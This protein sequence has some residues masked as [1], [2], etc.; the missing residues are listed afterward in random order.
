MGTCGL[1]ASWVPRGP[2][3][4]PLGWRTAAL[5]PARGPPEGEQTAGD[6]LS[7]R[8]PSPLPCH[9]S[10]PCSSPGL[11]CGEWTRTPAL[12]SPGGLAPGG[13][14]GGQG[15]TEVRPGPSQAPPCSCGH[16]GCPVLGPRCCPSALSSPRL[17]GPRVPGTLQPCLA[18][19]LGAGF[20]GCLCVL[21]LSPMV[22][23][24]SLCHLCVWRG[25]GV[26]AGPGAHAPA[27]QRELLPG[28]TAGGR[29][30]LRVRRGQGRPSRQQR[31]QC[32]SVSHVSCGRQHV[33]VVMCC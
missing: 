10:C 27:V 22:R 7:G 32:P 20:T 24:T 29:G 14:A 11:G 23:T 28:G 19:S 26:S 30:I 12:W 18:V 25:H 1:W 21:S 8:G 2:V 5:R 16:R 33:V 17:M 13:L 9:P 31:A 4:V 3:P 15:P 6:G